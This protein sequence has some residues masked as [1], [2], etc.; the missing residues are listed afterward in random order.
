MVTRNG[1]AARRAHLYRG[2]YPFQFPE[3]KPDFDVVVWQE[4]VDRRL[5]WGIA[6]AM[7]LGL[8]VKGDVIVCVQGWKGG[9]GNTNT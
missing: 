4:D 5:K 6:E 1:S 9:L 8:V 2:V 3:E 7:K